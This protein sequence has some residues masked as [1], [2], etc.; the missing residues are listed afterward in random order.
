MR[1]DQAKTTVAIVIIAGAVAFLFF[2]LR[3]PRPS[4]DPR[5]DRA[6]GEVVAAEAVKSL[7]SGGR[8][9]VITRDP[10]LFENPASAFQIEAFYRAL[11]KSNVA[12]AATNMVQQDPLRLVRVPPGAY[13]DIMKKLGDNDVIVSF[14]GPPI[15]N[16]E[17]KASM[18]EKR[19]H[20]VA[21]CS[22]WLPREVDVKELFAQKLLHVAIVSRLQAA[23]TPPV[24]NNPREW[25]DHYYEVITPANLSELQPAPNTASR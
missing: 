7:G 19:P 16:D 21:V 14:L 18:G 3:E 8:L 10:A 6:L 9:T 23:P 25:F 5:A 2:S 11:K 15:L 1:T 4:V 22:G 20:I 17:Q 13:V 12:L 24:S